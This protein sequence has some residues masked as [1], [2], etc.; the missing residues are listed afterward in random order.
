VV[1]GLQ[2]AAPGRQVRAV[3]LADSAIAGPQETAAAPAPAGASKK[4]AP[5]AS[6]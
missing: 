6:K 2:K 4:P 5:G 1:D 3:A